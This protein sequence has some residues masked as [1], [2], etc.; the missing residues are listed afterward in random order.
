VVELSESLLTHP[1]VEGVAGF[2]AIVFALLAPIAAGAAVVGLVLVPLTMIEAF[3]IGVGTTVVGVA[4]FNRILYGTLV[5]EWIAGF[6]AWA[7][8]RNL[9]VSTGGE[10]L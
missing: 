2:F 3:F 8:A 1:V 9:T 4:L 10:Q 7:E 5:Y 6:I